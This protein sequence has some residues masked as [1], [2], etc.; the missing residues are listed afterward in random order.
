[1]DEAIQRQIESIISEQNRRPVTE[2]EGYSPLEMQSILYET[3]DKNCPVQL[4][5]MRDSEY[6][7]VPLLGTVKHLANHL[8]KE[9]EVRLTQRGYLPP[10]IAHE[11]FEI[12]RAKDDYIVKGTTKL[13]KES[14]CVSISLIRALSEVSGLIKKR[15]NRLSL[16]QKGKKALGNNHQLLY[17]LFKSLGEKHNLASFDGYGDFMIGQMAYGYTL[18]LLSK[19]GDINR[20]SAFYSEKYFKAFPQLA[21][22]PIVDLYQSRFES[23]TNFYHLRSFKRFLAYFSI[24][25]IKE[26]DKLRRE[27]VAKTKLFDK[28]ISC[29]P[30][31]CL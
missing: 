28:M 11:M 1:M 3:F 6:D 13:T 5:E 31:L 19:Y 16:T 14:D 24:V 12:I 2:F 30:P 25:D 21:E 9:G 17:I 8:N 10:K 26:T 22:L 18:T 20:D 15:Q 27:T 23:L 7:A 4:L 29:T